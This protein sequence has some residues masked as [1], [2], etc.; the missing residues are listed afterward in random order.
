MMKRKVLSL[1]LAA[2]LALPL[3]GC[4]AAGPSSS[5]SGPEKSSSVASAS[6]SS[7]ALS[8]SA[9]P[10]PD[11][12]ADWHRVEMKTA[13]G[14]FAL[15]LPG[16]VW[17]EDTLIHFVPG[18]LPAEIYTPD[19][20]VLEAASLHGGD[21]KWGE[22]ALVDARDPAPRLNADG[23][24]TVRRLDEDETY[25]LH[26]GGD[27]VEQTYYAFGDYLVYTSWGPNGPAAP[28]LR[29]IYH[30]NID[31]DTDFFLALF[32]T[33]GSVDAKSVFERIAG[34]VEVLEV[35][36]PAQSP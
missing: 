8:S 17:C 18:A 22:A 14:R 31:A 2:L 20:A 12:D 26:D 23:T 21:Y 36:P 27:L 1:L 35:F 33:A 13:R 19:E 6:P 7:A 34:S 4:T 24:L 28:V 15:T 3:A 25:A 16:G 5:S 30:K 10:A 29:T 32:S 9:V 11:F